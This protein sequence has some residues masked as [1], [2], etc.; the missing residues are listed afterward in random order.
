MC[1]SLS[2]IGWIVE[3]GVSVEHFQEF[4]SK[5]KTRATHCAIFVQDWLSATIMV[6]MGTSWFLR[7][8]APSV[9]KKNHLSL[10]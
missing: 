2:S 9:N 6:Q 8:I 7:F 1:L 10:H 3:V 5:L 4:N